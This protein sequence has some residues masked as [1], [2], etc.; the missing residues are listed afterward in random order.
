MAQL[1][2]IAPAATVDKLAKLGVHSCHE[3]MSISSIMLMQ[4][5]D[6]SLSSAAC[7]LAAAAAA[8]AP[9]CISVSRAALA[10][11]AAQRSARLGP[12]GTALQT[13]SVR[14]P[15]PPT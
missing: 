3:L 10:R 8:I 11:A 9:P 12:G 4:W 1:S 7:L 15:C 2:S 14:L 6:T 13:L 5:L